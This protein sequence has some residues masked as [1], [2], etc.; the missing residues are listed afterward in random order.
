V[1]VVLHGLGEG[2][3][4]LAEGGIRRLRSLRQRAADRRD[5]ERVGFLAE[6]EGACLAAATDHAAG[7]RREPGQV[8]GLP[9]GR[10]R[11]ELWREAGREQQLQPERE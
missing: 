9:T 2:A 11:S 10:A 4:G 3:I 5:H 1:G 8:V 6:R 7:S